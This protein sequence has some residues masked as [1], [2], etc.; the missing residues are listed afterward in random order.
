M[1]KGFSFS[2]PRSISLGGCITYIGNSSSSTYPLNGCI[3]MLAFTNRYL[4]DE[5]SLINKCR[6][7]R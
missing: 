3:E 7:T 1:D 6:I 2:I 4:E 5:N